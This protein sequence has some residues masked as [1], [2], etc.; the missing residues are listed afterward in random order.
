MHLIYK[1]TTTRGTP[2]HAYEQN[3]PLIESPVHP[4]A[5]VHQLS[6]VNTHTHTHIRTI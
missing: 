3:N 2:Q 1:S 6:P 5:E 4:M